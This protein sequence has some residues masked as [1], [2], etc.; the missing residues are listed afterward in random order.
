MLPQSPPFSPVAGVTFIV[1][2]L[3]V[4]ATLQQGQEAPG[5]PSLTGL[6]V[7]VHLN[8]SEG[9]FNMTMFSS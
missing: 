5:F 7:C 9:I 3:G 1:L 6:F 4:L 8:F 2:N